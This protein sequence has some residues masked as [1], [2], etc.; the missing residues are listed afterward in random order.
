MI[1]NFPTASRYQ[2][3]RPPPTILLTATF[4]ARASD[5]HGLVTVEASGFE[6]DCGPGCWFRRV[7]QGYL[8]NHV[9]MPLTH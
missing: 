9:I 1:K 7:R 3:E 8:S 2:T 5:R 4:T 6:P